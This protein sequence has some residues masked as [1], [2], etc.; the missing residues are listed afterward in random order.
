MQ[1]TRATS[2]SEKKGKS[3]HCAALLAFLTSASLMMNS[4]YDD[5]EDGGSRGE[6]HDGGVVDA[7]DGGVVRWGDPAG[8]RHQEHRHVQ[9]GRDT[10]RHL[11]KI[12]GIAKIF[13][14]IPSITFSPD[15]AGI[16]NT[17][18]AMMLINTAGW[19]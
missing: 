19:M 9:H 2:C 4:E 1:T 12:F 11:Y 5:T 17:K 16:R 7:E 8:H 14:E 10:Q 6:D 3:T 15:S 13:V 18:R